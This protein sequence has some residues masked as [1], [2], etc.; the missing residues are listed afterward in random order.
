MDQISLALNMHSLPLLV[1]GG[2]AAALGALLMGARDLFS[3]RDARLMASP[4]LKKL[5]TRTEEVDSGAVGRF[6][7]W[8]E[9]AVYM[10][11]MNTGITTATALFVLIGMTFGLGVYVFSENPVYTGAAAFLGTILCFVILSIAYRRVMKQFDEQFPAAMDLLAR[12]VRAGESLDRALVMIGN[13]VNDPVAC[14]F[15][16]IAKQLEMGLS[17]SAAMKSFA[18]RVPTMDV[19][20]FASALSV[21]RESGGNLPKTL[22][23]LSRVIR[24]RMSYQRQLRSV[25]GA[26]RISATI[27]AGLGPL[28]FLYLFFIQPEYSQTLW[29]NPT[30]R[31]IL[32][33]AAASQVV[34]LLIVARMLRS[35]Y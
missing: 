8:L 14:E 21:H 5:P 31:I 4:I 7:V 35:R 16:R 22:E 27:I 19:R 15:R 29:N 12:A 6:D 11:G 33:G 34:G 10:T 17:L 25:T 26:G 18:Y 30:G 32:I 9:R 3:S 23:R 28:L 13:S 20:I 1:F 2:I 24:D